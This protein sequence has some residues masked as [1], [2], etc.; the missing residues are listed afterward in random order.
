MKY[1]LIALLA[2]SGCTTQ[3]HWSATGGSRSDATVTL[4]YEVSEFEKAQLSAS[5]AISLAKRRCKSWGYRGA[6]AFGG[7]TRSC[8]QF[9]GFNGCRTWIVSKE[10]QC[11][12]DGDGLS[13]ASSITPR[14]QPKKAAETKA[15]GKYQYT[16]GELAKDHGCEPPSLLTQSPPV[17]MYQTMCSGNHY[18]IKCEWNNC[19]VVN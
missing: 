19:N 17:E 16:A 11:S 9:G 7:S 14:S 12:G 5:E 8:A 4:S 3:K 1:L 10:F 2:L 13:Q 18:V 15:T 6:E